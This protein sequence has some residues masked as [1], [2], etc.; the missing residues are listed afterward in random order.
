MQSLEINAKHPP[1]LIMNILE[2]LINLEFTAW[3]E[4]LASK[5][6]LG[7]LLSSPLSVESNALETHH[8]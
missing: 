3:A 8:Y 4:Q 6:A 2:S 5:L 1:L 7:I